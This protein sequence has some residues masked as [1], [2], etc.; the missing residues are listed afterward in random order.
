MLFHDIY[1]VIVEDFMEIA[2][3]GNEN[4]GKCGDIQS[5]DSGGSTEGNLHKLQDLL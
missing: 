5:V 3:V 4:G 2:I 1:Y